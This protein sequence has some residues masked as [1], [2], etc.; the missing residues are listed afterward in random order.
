VAAFAD[1]LASGDLRAAGA[2]MT[3]SHASMRDDFDVSTSALDELVGRVAA[4][5]GVWGARLTGAG[6][7][8]CAV[9]LAEPGTVSR[10]EGVSSW[11]VTAVGPAH[12]TS[13]P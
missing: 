10:I 8:G 13:V 9:A 5:P 7:A 6:F 2:L 3:E 12:L 4:T 11:T 1:A